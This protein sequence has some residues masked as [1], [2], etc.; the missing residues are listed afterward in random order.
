MKRFLLFVPLF[1][2]FVVF[3][4]P[5]ELILRHLLATRL[6][7]GTT[8]TFADVKP[9]L[10]PLGYRLT[11]VAI[12]Q[13]NVRAEIDS[14]VASPRLFGGIAFEASACGGLVTGQVARSS[15]T[16]SGSA[17]DL[18]F[19]FSDIDP[20]TCVELDGPRLSGRFDGNATLK[21]FGAGKGPAPLGRLAKA[22]QF[23]LRGRG[24]SL[25]GYLPAAQRTKGSG[26]QREPQPIG[27]WEFASI[28]LDGEIRDDRVALTQGRAEAEGLAWEII[29]AS[30]LAS[31]PSPRVS[32]ELRARRIDDSTRSR[33]IIGLLP[34]TAEK[35]GWYRYRVTGT[36][37]KV[38]IGGVK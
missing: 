11:D 5:H 4:F 3:T 12:D 7:A 33:A 31:G 6:P 34:K 14:L 30:L 32:I 18:E 22:G 24:G 17:R 15:V 19:R 1:L 38:Q 25:S 23:S 37:S 36:V 28:S 2:F 13:S 10:W 16:E 35:D 20:A 8:V 9:S 29:Q 27:E 26:K 21:A